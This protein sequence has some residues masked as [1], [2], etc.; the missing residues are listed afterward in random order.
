[1][2]LVDLD[3]AAFELELY[4]FAQVLRQIAHQARKLA[5]QS[6]H[7]LHTGLR[8]YF[9]QFGGHQTD[10][11]GAGADAAFVPPVER[12]IQLVAAE[13]QFAGQ[14]HQRIE[15]RNVQADGGLAGRNR[16]TA[17]WFGGGF[18]L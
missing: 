5:E 6:A 13:H 10:P 9:L 11:L 18:I 2:R 7:R 17:G 3:L 14:C 16:I 12:F 8:N 15:Q 4:L 1:M